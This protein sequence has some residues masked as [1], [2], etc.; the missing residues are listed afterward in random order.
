VLDALAFDLRPADESDIPLREPHYQFADGLQGFR[1]MRFK[2]YS[3]PL[4]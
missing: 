4:D 1:L 3:Y 2:D